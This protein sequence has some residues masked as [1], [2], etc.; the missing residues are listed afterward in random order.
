MV[1]TPATDPGSGL[2]GYAW[3][4]APA[5]TWTCDQVKDLEE[6]ATSLTTPEIGDGVWYV[7]LCAG[8]NV[9]LWGDAVTAGPYLIC[10]LFAD[11]FES[12]GTAAW[13]ST[14]P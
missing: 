2:D 11:G 14:F 6:G 1:W 7:H 10:P 12:G 5:A 8:D 3:E 4:V 13:S 9:G